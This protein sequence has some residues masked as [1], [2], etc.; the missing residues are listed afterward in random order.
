VKFYERKIGSKMC[1]MPFCGVLNL[2]DLFFRVTKTMLLY[3]VRKYPFLYLGLLSG[4]KVLDNQ[5]FYFFKIEYYGIVF[6]YML[7]SREYLI[8]LNK[9][10]FIQGGCIKLKP[11]FSFVLVPMVKGDISLVYFDP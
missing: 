4:K 9:F 3:V 7:L 2:H 5:V 1:N 6:L 11:M 8:F 10:K